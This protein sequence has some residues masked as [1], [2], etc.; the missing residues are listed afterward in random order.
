RNG[1]GPSRM[2]MPDRRL[3]AF[4]PDIADIRLKGRV[5]A[6]RFEEGRTAPVV[7]PVVD[8]RPEPR[9]ERGI[10]TQ[11]LFGDELRV[12][13][14][15]DGWAWVQSVHDEYVG[16]VPDSAFATGASQ[17]SHRVTAT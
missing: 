3:N 8:L 9:A 12:F 7:L 11:L 1:E 13:D 16:Y 17:A 2:S 5:Q 6:A 14:A 4:R 10:D 15:R